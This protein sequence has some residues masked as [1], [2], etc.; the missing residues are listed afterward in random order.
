MDT[1]V[2]T[3]AQAGFGSRLREVGT[4][5]WDRPTPCS[6]WDV[7]ALVNHVV[8]ANRRYTMLLGDAPP[9]DVQATHQLDHL[10]DDPVGRFDETSAEVIAAF[11]AP[12]AAERTVHH[13]IG[14]RTG[15]DL[16]AMKVLDVVV[17]TWDLARAIG[18]DDRLDRGAVELAWTG[19]PLVLGAV[20]GTFAPPDAELAP[21]AGPQDR[22]L[23][24][25]GRHLDW[26][27]GT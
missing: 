2:L 23:H 20:P 4:A 27:T 3:V 17:H 16:L 24:A 11:R 1:D 5:D 7:R 6:E 10:A 25:V 18:A 26:R 8:G 13:R 14:D 12:G 15:R 19:L 21:G 9:S 22:L